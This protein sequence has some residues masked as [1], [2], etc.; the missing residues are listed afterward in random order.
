MPKTRRLLKDVI[1]FPELRKK[2]MYKKITK[3]ILITYVILA[4]LTLA[5]NL[6]SLITGIKPVVSPTPAMGLSISTEV[7]AETVQPGNT[8][9]MTSPSS[10]QTQRIPV[11]TIVET[12]DTWQAETVLNDQGEVTSFTTGQDVYKEQVYIPILGLLLLPFSTSLAAAIT[13]ALALII[14]FVYRFVFYG[15]PAKPE[16]PATTDNI[17]ILQT[18]FDNAPEL[19]KKEAVRLTKS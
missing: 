19:T 5:L 6:T 7:P 14:I 16:P 17:G 13:S 18:M 12:G 4:A 15:K 9:V 8:I 10:G 2:P 1:Y 3:A 11:S